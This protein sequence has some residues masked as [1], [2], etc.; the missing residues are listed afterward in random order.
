MCTKPVNKLSAAYCQAQH[1]RMAAMLCIGMLQ[2][3]SYNLFNYVNEV[4]AEV[5]ALEDSIAKVRVEIEAHLDQV[6]VH[7]HT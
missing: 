6:R 3:A 7:W 1:T 4:N 2:S 5:E